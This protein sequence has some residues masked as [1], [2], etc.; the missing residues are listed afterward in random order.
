MID[1]YGRDI[2]YMRI[3]VTD[4][5]NLRCHYCTSDYMEHV[6]HEHLL[7]YEEI[8]R[9]AGCAVQLG[10]DTFRITGGEP[11]VRRDVDQLIMG[12]NQ[13]TGTKRVLMTTNGKLLAEKLS[14]LIQAGLS[15]VNI[16]LDTLDASQYLRI[17]GKAA[18]QDTLAGIQAAIEAHLPVKINCVLQK[19]INEDQIEALVGLTKDQNLMV[20]FIEMMPLG[21]G[22]EV[23]GVSN[24]EVL[25]V[26]RKRYP[27]MTNESYVGSGPAVYYR[28]PKHQGMIGF[29]SPI[30]QKFCQNC[31]RVRLTS[32]GFLKTCLASSAGIDLRELIRAG[33]TDEQLTLIMQ[34]TIYRKPREHCFEEPAQLSEQKNMNQIGG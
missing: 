12:L 19:G 18:L 17:T 5:C 14:S 7:T 25:E 4:R 9:I 24:V 21:R 26:L 27:G 20:R 23:A 15:G 11:L 1:Q 22:K 32:E 33:I 28:L 2:H 29:I 16:S 3:S 6:S 8:I 31:N 13:F 30:H 34:E 10:F